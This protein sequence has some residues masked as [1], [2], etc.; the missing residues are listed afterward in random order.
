LLDWQQTLFALGSRDPLFQVR[1]FGP[2]HE[3]APVSPVATPVHDDL[4]FL[5]W[6]L[7][8]HAAVSILRPGVIR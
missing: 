6:M 1:Q 8:I 5:S 7:W 2:A 4:V 3:W